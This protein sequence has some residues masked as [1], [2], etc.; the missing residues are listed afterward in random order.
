MEQGK[1]KVQWNKG[2]KMFNRINTIFNG[3]L[4]KNI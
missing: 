1:D 4:G 2:N 3:V